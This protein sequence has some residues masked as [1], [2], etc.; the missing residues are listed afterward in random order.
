[1]YMIE[2]FLNDGIS[3]QNI[4]ILLELLNHSNYHTEK[5][6]IRLLYCNENLLF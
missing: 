6:R 4:I 2:S 3:F 5:Y 1:M